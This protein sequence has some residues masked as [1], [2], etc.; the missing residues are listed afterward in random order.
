[1]RLPTPATVSSVFSSSE[2][3]S[4]LSLYLSPVLKHLP[5]PGPALW[6]VTVLAL[7]SAGVRLPGAAAGR[8]RGGSGARG[9][10]L[11]W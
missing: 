4:R 8:C 9:G 6:E 11:L 10:V 2:S 3:V 1:M 7:C 5:P